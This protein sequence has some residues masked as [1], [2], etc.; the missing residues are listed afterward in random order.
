MAGWVALT[1][2]PGTGKT[3][4][5]DRIKERWPAMEVGDL[6]LKTRTGRRLRDGDVEVDMERLSDWIKRESARGKPCVVVGHLAHLLPIR[7][8]VLLRCHP[9]ELEK[10]LARARRGDAEQ[11]RANAAAEATDLILR[12]AVDLRRR[13]WEVDTTGRSVEDVA[14]EV[15]GQI[16]RRGPARYATVAWLTDPEVTEH[17][18]DGAS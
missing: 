8:A 15:A 10:R 5:A 17:L 9:L 2:T 3:A 7:D 13:I 16:A 14:R 11:R 6:A 18:L 4:V 12:E 1:G